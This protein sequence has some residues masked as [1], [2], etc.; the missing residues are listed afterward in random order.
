M[1]SFQI[2]RTWTKINKLRGSEKDPSTL[3]ANDDKFNAKFPNN[4]GCAHPKLIG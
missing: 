1:R 2:F 3:L 4:F